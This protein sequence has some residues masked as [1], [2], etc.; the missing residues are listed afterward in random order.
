MNTDLALCSVQV[1]GSFG[2]VVSHLGLPK[3]DAEPLSCAWPEGGRELQLL[4]V[5][6]VRQF[7]DAVVQLQIAVLERIASEALEC[8]HR[9]L[10]QDEPP[11]D[12]RQP[13][14]PRKGH[15]S[16]EGLGRRC[17]GVPPVVHPA[18][19]DA[20]TVRRIAVR[21]SG[22]VVGAEVKPRRRRDTNLTQQRSGSYQNTLGSRK[23]ADPMSSTG[24]RSYLCQVR[25]RSWLAAR[26]CACQP[27]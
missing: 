1:E 25:P 8:R 24:L 6:V 18:D 2:D 12:S 3:P 27:V 20:L 15:R 17:G 10:R 26:L 13:V 19:Q 4:A 7:V 16:A 9:L 23:S 22:V 11:G 21:H 14:D 5:L